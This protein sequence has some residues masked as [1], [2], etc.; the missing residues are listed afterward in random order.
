[1]T[2]HDLFDQLP[3]SRAVG[4]QTAFDSSD[5]ALVVVNNDNNVSDLNPAARDLFSVSTLDCIGSP[6]NDLLPDT[7][8]SDNLR[9]SEPIVFRIPNSDTIIEAVMTT[10][11]DDNTAIGRT[12]VLIDITD[13]RRRQQRIQVLNRILRHNLR[14]D[15][16]AA[17]G[18]VGVMADGGPEAESSQQ[19]VEGILDDLVTIGKKAQSTEN[20]L[21]AEPLVDSPTQL[22]VLI[23]DAIE[24]V[25]SE[26]D[27]VSVSGSVPAT[28]A[29]RINPVIIGSVIEEIIENAVR[30]TDS[31]ITISYDAET[32]T[33]TIADDG[34]GIPD[35]EIVV[36][37]T[38]QETDLQHGS[39]LGLW[40]VKWGTDSFGGTVH[41]DTDETGTSVRI[42]LPDDLV[43]KLD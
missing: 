33:L 30:H 1:V 9:Q 43:E 18:Y 26:Y 8:D 6:L 19:K 25:K 4:R 15:L 28:V 14:N 42:D 20:V 24:S 5:T 39:G 40:L 23:T 10:A 38:A 37:D 12:I 13:E 17:K 29:L 41:F 2:R 35:H 34:P 27:S 22:G 31:A 7:V 11:T 21:E 3:A 36:L 16:N 32:T